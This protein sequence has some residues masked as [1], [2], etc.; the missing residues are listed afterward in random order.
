VNKGRDVLKLGKV[1]PRESEDEALS[2]AGVEPKSNGQNTKSKFTSS[3]QNASADLDRTVSNR[4]SESHSSSSQSEY[5]PDSSEDD[6]AKSALKGAPFK[7]SVVNSRAAGSEFANSSTKKS[8]GLFG[9]LRNV[10]SS[11]QR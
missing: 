6:S 5:S 11:S 8:K 1:H 2:D 9:G 4:K 7:G 10:F 3:I